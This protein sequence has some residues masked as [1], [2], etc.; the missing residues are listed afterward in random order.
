MSSASPLSYPQWKAIAAAQLAEKGIDPKRI[1][2]R[3]WRNLYVNGYNPDRA[4]ERAA[5]D[6]RNSQTDWSKPK[7]PK[8]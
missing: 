5:T 7:Q 4:A 6:Y 8:R 1:S 2:E 3:A